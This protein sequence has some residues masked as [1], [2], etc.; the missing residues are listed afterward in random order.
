MS[1]LDNFDL[2]ESVTFTENT[3]TND[4]SGN[5]VKTPVVTGPFDC[6][7]W[8][9]STGEAFRSDKFREEVSAT[10]ALYPGPTVKKDMIAAIGGSNYHVLGSDDIGHV[11]EVLVVYLKEFT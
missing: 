8:E 3:I 10:I 9:G 11:A 5:R 4:G 1:I 7:F 2:N 6:L